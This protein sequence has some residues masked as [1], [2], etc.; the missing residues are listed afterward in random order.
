MKQIHNVDLEGQN[1]L[2]Y[3]LIFDKY[4]R[5]LVRYL[6]IQHIRRLG[7]DS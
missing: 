5:E 4:L 2:F 7:R 6:H 3:Y 1:T